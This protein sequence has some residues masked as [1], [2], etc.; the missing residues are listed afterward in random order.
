MWKYSRGCEPHQ[1]LPHWFPIAVLPQLGVPHNSTAFMHGIFV[2]N[3]KE[4][5]HR[6]QA[7]LGQQDCFPLDPPSPRVNWTVSPLTLP[8]HTS[9]HVPPI[10]SFSDR[11]DN[12][13][14]RGVEGKY[15]PWGLILNKVKSNFI[16]PKY[17]QLFLV[18]KVLPL[19][20]I[21]KIHPQL[22]YNRQTT[23]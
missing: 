22:S 19:P 18:P 2:C 10:M 14:W 17:S 5:T 6:R 12:S 7:N 3:V 23:E 11:R 9:S 15:T 4:H 13:E 1:D 8:L 16:S 20:K 21:K